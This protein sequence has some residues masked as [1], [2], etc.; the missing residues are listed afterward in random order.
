MV[1]EQDA[2]PVPHDE[3]DSVRPR[4][5][6]RVA[7]VADNPGDWMRHCHVMEHQSVG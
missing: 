2:V 6:A 1:V 3:G 7:F 4:E 5:R